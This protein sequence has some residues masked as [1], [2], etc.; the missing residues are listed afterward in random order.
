MSFK[1]FLIIQ[2]RPE[3]ETSNSEFNAILKNAE[4]NSNDV[5]RLRA[6]ISGLPEIDLDKYSGIIVGGSPFDISTPE[7]E[8]SDVQK[9]VERDFKPLLDKVISNDFPFLGVCSGT[10]QLGNFCGVNITSKYKE[11]ISAVDIKLTDDGKKDKLLEGVVGEFRA[12]VGHKEAC[13]TLPNGAELLASS[14]TCP[15]QMFRLGENVYATQFH[16]EADAEEFIVRIKAYKYNGYFKPEDAEELIE[17]VGREKITV[18][19]RILKNF[20]EVY[21][22]S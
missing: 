15:V 2:L 14:D 4:L 20:V 13:D 18:P 10:G 19:G 17:T 12:M 8:K 21:R 1:P 22:K 7:D 9:M 5:E 16:P 3:D 6:E 11:P